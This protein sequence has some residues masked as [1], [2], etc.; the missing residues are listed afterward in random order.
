MHAHGH[1]PDCCVAAKRRALAKIHPGDVM[2]PTWRR[3]SVIAK[4]AADDPVHW[5]WLHEI[6]DA[7]APEI[8]RRFIAAIASIRGTIKEAQVRAA[9]ETGNIEA[10]M[11]ALGLADSTS[12][13]TG[14]IDGA[15]MPVLTD[16]VGQTAAAALDATPALSVQGGS[17]A[18]RFDLVNP[19]TVQA[20]RNYG[21]N[22]IR[23]VTDDTRNGIRAIVSHA[24]EFG[25]HPSQQA[26]QIRDMIGLTESQ[27]AAVTNF[28]RLIE[29]RDP[30]AL[31]RALRDRRFDPTLRRIVADASAAPPSPEQVD[32]MVN[33]YASRMLNFRANTIARTETLRAANIGSEQALIQATEHGLLNRSK[34]R[35]GWMVTP[36]DRLCIY[37]AAVP[38]M[39]PEGV[40]LGQPFQ[41]PLGPIDNPPLHPNCRCVT[42]LLAF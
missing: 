11:R 39:N 14:I 38:D 6:A 32:R 13:T 2:Q 35:R 26:R 15:L 29:D 22:L 30:A 17:L 41:T 10:V 34:V 25:G 4:A 7:Q 27:A 8:R 42:Y 9:L 23:Q 33:Q 20:V 36:D 12:A 31:D 16:T 1:G 37:C 5:E 21:F 24:L 28:R 40:A 18:M 19:S 3:S